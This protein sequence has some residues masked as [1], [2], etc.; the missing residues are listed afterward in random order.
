[1]DDL[2]KEDVNLR[3]LMESIEKIKISLGVPVNYAQPGEDY[4]VP[5]YVPER[6]DPL[7]KQPEDELPHQ[8]RCSGCGL[9]YWHFFGDP[10]GCVYCRDLA[11]LEKAGEVAAIVTAGKSDISKVHGP[12]RKLPI[13]AMIGIA[14][15]GLGL[16]D[17]SLP[18][19]YLVPILLLLLIFM[20]NRSKP[21]K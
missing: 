9:E 7:P 20:P 4:P 17:Y 10:L 2:E 21:K 18:T 1:V 15:L 3:G 13:T 19:W 14:L 8:M 5:V 6:D 16:S 12:L 11:E